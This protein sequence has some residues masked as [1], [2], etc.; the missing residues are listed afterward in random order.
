MSKTTFTLGLIVVSA[1]LAWS[2][3]FIMWTLRGDRS[4]ISEGE[5][6]PSE[7]QAPMGGIVELPDRTETSGGT[8]ST[9]PQPELEQAQAEETPKVL[10]A[11]DEILRLEGLSIPVSYAHERE[12]VDMPSYMIQFNSFDQTFIIALREG[13]ISE[14]RMSAEAHLASLLRVSVDGLCNYKIFV[15]ALPTANRPYNPDL[16]LSSCPGAQ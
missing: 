7:K 9:V 3:F 1:L 11:D 16:G 15:V 13:D 5:W 12:L 10:L 8:L 4:S 14:I 6:T 2:A